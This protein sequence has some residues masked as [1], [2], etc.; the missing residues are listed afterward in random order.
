MDRSAAGPRC[1]AVTGMNARPDNPGPGVAV[2]RCLRE[3]ANFSGRVVGLGYEALDP[4]LHLDRYADAGYLLPYPSSGDDAFLERLALIHGRERLD[5]LIPCLD[6]ELPIVTRLAAELEAMG[7][8]T[9]MPTPAQLELRNKDRLDELAS[10]AGIDAPR[11]KA[12]ADAGFFYNCGEQGWHYPFVVKGIFYDAAIVHN[13]SE[14]ESAFRRIASQWG[15]PVLV[16][17]FL[18]GE[19][20]NLTA[21]GDGEG[22]L[23]SPVMMK[24]LALT[25]KGKAWAGISIVDDRLLEA[26]RRLVAA[27]SWRGPLEVEVMRAD[28][29]SYQLIEINP[30]F[31]AWIYL[32]AGTG[33]N[34][35]E[36]LLRCMRGE[37]VDDTAPAEAG[38]IY[39]RHAEDSIV[40]LSQYESVVV[41]GWR[42]STTAVRADAPRA[43]APRE[44][45][46]REEYRR[47][48][49]RRGDDE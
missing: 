21:V 17:A 29:G 32:S 22:R 45:D 24:K 14:A 12:I 23:L 16:Q 49:Y 38:R 27:T 1:I 2:A 11:T 44:D 31:P 43:D 28:D 26:S 35:L 3:A 4:G 33:R 30:R 18:R 37:A 36:V 40:S 34:L 19:E 46:R 25:D 6:A 9:F 48:E 41:N 5:A 15:Y 8:A 20:V 7:I 39:L 10:H 13:P 47:E 42:L